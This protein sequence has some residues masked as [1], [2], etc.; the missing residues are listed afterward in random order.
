MYALYKDP[1][2]LKVFDRTMPSGN[3]GSG[4]KGNEKASGV[5]NTST[6]NGKVSSNLVWGLRFPESICNL[7]I[8]FRKNRSKRRLQRRCKT[9]IYT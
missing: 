5:F 1:E 3:V 8:S 9:D 2:G 6:A 4:S 7:Y